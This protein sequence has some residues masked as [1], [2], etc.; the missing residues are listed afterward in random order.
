S[1]LAGLSA[2]PA[3]PGGWGSDGHGKTPLPPRYSQGPVHQLLRLGHALR[4]GRRRYLF[5]GRAGR[6]RRLYHQHSHRS[7][8]YPGVEM[9]RP[10]KNRLGRAAAAGFTLIELILVIAIMGILLGLAI[11]N[12][13]TSVRA[14]NEAVLHDDLF[15]FRSLIS[16]YTLDKQEAPQS[17]DDLV[18]AGYLRAIPVDPFTH[19]SSSWQTSSDDTIASPD[20][21]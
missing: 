15:Q 13:R 6:L 2:R 3:N 16:Q 7:G 10:Y 11:P 1:R 19:S 20:Q 12:Y 4:P 14:A 18:S 17:L 9:V 21:T 5:V 8:R